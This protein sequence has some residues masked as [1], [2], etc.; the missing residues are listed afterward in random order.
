MDRKVHTNLT[1]AMP[2]T[3]I[4]LESRDSALGFFFFFSFV[5]V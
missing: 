4:A 3:G 2:A 5:V 1:L